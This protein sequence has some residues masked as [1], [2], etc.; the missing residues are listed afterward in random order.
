LQD[1]FQ[2]KGFKI[3][4]VF[5]DRRRETRVVDLMKNREIA[6]VI[7][8]PSGK[9]PRQDEIK[10]RT[11]AYLYSIPVITTCQGVLAAA[12][13]IEALIH[14]KIRVKSIYE[15]HHELQVTQ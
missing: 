12:N 6:L 3:D 5:K 10:I 15:Y 4:K 9:K 7:N 11:N 14:G 2:D 8:T 13:G 1:F